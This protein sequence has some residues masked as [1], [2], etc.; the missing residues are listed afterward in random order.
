MNAFFK[1]VSLGIA[2]VLTMTSLT[3]FAGE[4][5]NNDPNANIVALC[6]CIENGGGN[7]CGKLDSANAPEQNGGS[8]NRTAAQAPQH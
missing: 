6:N 5:S 4:L 7:S 8:S 3:V 2:A 1:T